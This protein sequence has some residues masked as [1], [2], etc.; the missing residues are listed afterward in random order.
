MGQGTPLSE[1]LVLN[2]KVLK[3]SNILTMN[4]YSTIKFY[5]IFLKSIFLLSKVIQK[6]KLMNYHNSNFT[7]HLKMPELFYIYRYV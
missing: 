2:H 5:K 7:P 6:I 3:G 1:K 4:L